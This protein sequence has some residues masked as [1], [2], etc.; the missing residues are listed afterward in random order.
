M[1]ADEG[2]KQTFYD[3]GTSV[4]YLFFPYLQLILLWFGS[5]SLSRSLFLPLF[6]SPQFFLRFC[7]SVSFL[8]F[9]SLS[10]VFS[11]TLSLSL[12]LPFQTLFDCCTSV[13]FL[14]CIQLE[15]RLCFT[16]KKNRKLYPFKFARSN[17]LYFYTNKNHIYLIIY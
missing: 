7:I 9:I 1:S 2:L 3:C 6:L 11:R 4:S 15:S 10:H 13:K 8:L 16:Y 14:C 5:L 17:M 12:S